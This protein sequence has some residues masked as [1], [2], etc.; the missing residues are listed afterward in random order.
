MMPAY[1]PFPTFF[2]TP[3]CEE[4]APVSGPK[5]ILRHNAVKRANLSP[6]Q[7]VTIS[8]DVVAGATMK[9][10]VNT[11]RSAL[12]HGKVMTP[13]VR[14]SHDGLTLQIGSNPPVNE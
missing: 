5:P 2:W 6:G 14:I 8:P 1:R 10:K 13:K 11:L 9:D 12:N 4:A 3:R 7:W